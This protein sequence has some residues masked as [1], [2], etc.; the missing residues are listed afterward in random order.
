MK[1]T[2]LVLLAI[3]AIAN[4]PQ[5]ER[6]SQSRPAPQ[7]IEPRTKDAD[8]LGTVQAATDDLFGGGFMYASG[9]PTFTMV[10]AGRMSRNTSPW[11]TAMRSM[12]FTSL[13]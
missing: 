2:S 10:V 4:N 13:T 1:V 6:A 3:I 5:D 11:M 12:S 7:E 8:F 9:N